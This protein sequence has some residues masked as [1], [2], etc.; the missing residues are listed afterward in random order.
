GTVG[1]A[2]PATTITQS[3]GVGTTTFAVSSGA[4]PPGLTLST[5]GVVS[6]TPTA[7]GSFVFTVT[8]A[9]AN[10]CLGSRIYA[11]TV[12][13]TS[14][15]LFLTPAAVNFGAVNDAGTLTFVTPSQTLNLTQSGAGAVTWTVAATQPWITVSPAS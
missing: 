14:P 4:L 1:V 13:G 12:R 8:A 3:G 11:L 6:G 2:Y 7:V 10:G 5:T 9:D 15:T